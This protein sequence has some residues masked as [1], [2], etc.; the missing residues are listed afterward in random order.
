MFNIMIFWYPRND[1]F[2]RC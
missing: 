1:F 2:N